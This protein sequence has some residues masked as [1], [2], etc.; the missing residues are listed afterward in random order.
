M[1]KGTLITADNT[2]FI[3]WATVEDKLFD[4][5]CIILFN[6]AMM[7]RAFINIKYIL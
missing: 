3:L 2:V 6:E 7:S 1:Y 4:S 5:K